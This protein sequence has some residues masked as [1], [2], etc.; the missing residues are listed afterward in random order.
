MKVTIYN[1]ISVDGFIAGPEHD[2]SWVSDS[3]WNSL[4]R[5]LEKAGVVMMGSKTYEI[6][7]QGDSA[8]PYGRVMNYVFTQNPSK[9]EAHDSVTFSDG[10][11]V[12]FL[13]EYPNENVLIIGGGKLNAT[14]LQAGVVT[15]IITTV[16]PVILGAGTRQFADIDQTAETKLEKISEEDIGEDVVKIHYRVVAE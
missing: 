12:H 10:D 9:Y 8:I 15:D 5:E 7:L 14:L 3:D 16:H 13:N 11:P 4:E 1:A 6:S 2:T